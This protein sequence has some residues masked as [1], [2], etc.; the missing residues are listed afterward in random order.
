M[1]PTLEVI[2]PA[3]TPKETSHSSIFFSC[4][5]LLKPSRLLL[6]A[7]LLLPSLTEGLRELVLAGGVGGNMGQLGKLTYDGREGNLSPFI[8]ERDSESQ[9]CILKNKVA[10]VFDSKSEA[11]EGPKI[12]EFSCPSPDPQH[13]FI[14]WNN[15]NDFINDA[16]SPA[17]DAFYAANLVNKLFVDWYGIPVLQNRYGG[18]QRIVV[19]VNSPAI[20]WGMQRSEFHT[21]ELSNNLVIYCSDANFCR[22]ALDCTEQSYPYVSLKIVAHELGHAFSRLHERT[23][24]KEDK[25]GMSDVIYESFSDMCAIAAEYFQK[26]NVTWEVGGEINRSGE[27]ERYLDYPTLKGGSISHVSDYNPEVEVHDAT[28]IFSKA[29]YS[30]ATSENWN[31]KKAF[32]VMVYSNLFFWRGNSTFKSAACDVN[33]A[34]SCLQYDNAVV[35][36]AMS[37]VGIAVNDCPPIKISACPYT[38]F[39][40]SAKKKIPTTK[41]VKEI[42]DEWF[43]AA[44]VFDI[45]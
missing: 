3:P 7:L 40:M 11:R 15:N 43:R 33:Q 37:E 41:S 6:T 23:N 27:P 22:G 10:V 30:M 19:I 17:N 26:G 1:R 42:A 32:D 8:V 28:G 4:L 36:H 38:M 39:P 34:A 24:W 31:V 35:E 20:T 16:Y 13:N 29:F 14:Y 45:A 9:E 44:S 2:M 12:S 25:F 21:A 18:V 5:R